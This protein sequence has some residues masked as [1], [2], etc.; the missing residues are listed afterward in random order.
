MRGK[1]ENKT[2]FIFERSLLAPE[3]H[4]VKETAQMNKLDWKLL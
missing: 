2:I 4:A 3:W 1:Y